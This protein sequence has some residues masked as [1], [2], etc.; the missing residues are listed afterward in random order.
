MPKKMHRRAALSVLAATAIAAPNITAASASTQDDPIL[1][2][3]ENHRAAWAR[4]EAALQDYHADPSENASAYHDQCSA[5]IDTAEAAL[6][7]AR[8]T[9]VAGAAALATY[10]FT[11]MQD[12]AFD[13]PDGEALLNA[14]AEGLRSLAANS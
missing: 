9:T 12:M 2:A 5:A 14:L 4:S 8:P 6:I 10:L 7:D 11:E 1:A 3:I 13:Q